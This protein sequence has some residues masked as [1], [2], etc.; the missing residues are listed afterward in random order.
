[1]RTLSIMPSKPSKIA[2][3]QSDTM[4]NLLL[5]FSD[6]SQS[7]HTI[8]ES[9]ILVP[10]KLRFHGFDY[11]QVCRGERSAV[12]HQT[13]DGKTVG[14]EVFI[15]QKEPATT[16]YGKFYPSHERWARDRD[17]GKTAWSCFTLEEAMLKYNRIK[18]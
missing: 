17:W 2:C 7:L 4:D 3:R 10:R 12:Y 16:L 6:L 13:Y 11:I 1:M 9:L 14:Y 5:P 8:P 15:L 18:T